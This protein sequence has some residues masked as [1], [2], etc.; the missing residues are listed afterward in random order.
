MISNGPIIL[1]VDCDMYSN[2]SKSVRDALCFFMDEKQ[3]RQ[4]AFVQFPQKYAN[5]T[6]NDIYATSF[7][8]IYEVEF[9]G[10][11][12]N[13]GPWYIGSGCFHRRDILCGRRFSE[14]D[15]G[16]YLK[17][18]KEMKA[19]GSVEELEE[20]AKELA[21][22]TYELDSQWGKEVGL[23]YGIPVEDVITGL[24]IQ[25]RGWKSVYMNPKRAAFL[26]V[27]PTTLAQTLVQQKRW[28]E[29][30]FQILLTKFSPIWK[31]KP[32]KENMN[33]LQLSLD[34]KVFRTT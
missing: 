9:H 24:T 19:E 31:N 18:Q 11:D 32:E 34:N 16:I 26:G 12:G 27:A 25:C 4:I 30:D 1:N 8:I 6:K 29:G 13:G 28:S 20:T 33:D 10:L 17:R 15:S 14:E 7:K 21:S 23:K 2:N 22:C 3:S 5:V